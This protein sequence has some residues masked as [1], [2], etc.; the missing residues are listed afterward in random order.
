[1]RATYPSANVAL[2][3]A[4]IEASAGID[5]VRALLPS[6]ADA[7]P[8]TTVAILAEAVRFGDGV[9][10]P[11]NVSMD[12]VGAVLQ[13]GRVRTAPGHRQAW[14]EFVAAG[15]PS[16]DHSVS[17][18]G[19]QLPLALG[20]LVQEQF[21]RACPAFGMLPVPQRSAARLIA[22]FG[23]PSQMAEWLAGLAA[24]TIGATICMSESG[25][26][27]D[28]LQI[29]TRAR[30][31]QAGVWRVTG[32]K[33][34][35]SFGDHDLTDRILHCVL[36][37]S[38]APGDAPQISLFLVEG[39]AAQPEAVILRRIEAK[40]GL[41]GSPTCSL[42]FEG[43]RGQLLGTP[44]RGLQQMFVM[45]TQ[46]RLA[47]GS[48]G[49]GIAAGCTDTALAYAQERRQGGPIG[50][51][52]PISTHRDVQRQLME[53]VSRTEILRGVLVNTA[54]Q[55]D[56]ALHATDPAIRA[57]AAALT[58]WLLPIVKTMGAE[59]GFDTAS[60]ALQ[61]LGGAGYA[62][63]WPI[64]QALRDSRVL[65][66]F[67]GTSGIQALDLVHR[68][69]L[70]DST[71]LQAFL[72]V[73]RAADADGRLCT[74]LA[75]LEDGAAQ[76][77]AMDRL[78]GDVETGASAFLSLAILAAGGWV[79]SRFATLDETL[80]G[81]SRMTAAANWWLDH[82]DQRARLFHAET[83]V[84]AASLNNFQAVAGDA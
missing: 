33:C 44:G 7:T 84:G 2:L 22:A 80:P 63:D 34:W 43:A 81:H 48:L 25:A 62:R 61:V 54:N 30:Q 26:G 66:V 1:M 15:W 51:P 42:G 36:A 73:A 55:A 69:V 19:Q 82:I 18:G 29:G 23:D 74:C 41:H 12:G 76:L 68:R 11:L 67:E 70:R 38:E 65:A 50:H 32:E 83:L 17:Y 77:R 37:R 57:D 40:L 6:F 21:D 45:I 14:A 56:I 35:I 71:G 39:G 8:E 20:A 27:S 24:G 52:V 58:Q 75:L 5:D 59:T 16:L 10:A 9:L 3:A 72:G 28:A 64:E 46:M 31:D 53:M 4:H 49:L 79:A 78:S 60:A 47:V 13:A